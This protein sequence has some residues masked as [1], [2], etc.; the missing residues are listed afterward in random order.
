[1]ATKKLFISSSRGVRRCCMY[2]YECPSKG[3]RHFFYSTQRV[4]FL[5]IPRNLAD[6]AEANG[7]TAEKRKL[8]GY[9]FCQKRWGVKRNI[10]F[11]G[12]QN[13]WVADAAECA[14]EKEGEITRLY[15]RFWRKVYFPL[16]CKCVKNS[17]ANSSMKLFLSSHRPNVWLSMCTITLQLFDVL[18]WFKSDSSIGKHHTY[19]ITLNAIIRRKQLENS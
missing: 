10:C 13:Y 18:L 3:G 14:L 1:M 7:V 9:F 12:I 19:D 15:S 16:R 11:P 4:P 5:N 17:L 6:E 8:W 2:M